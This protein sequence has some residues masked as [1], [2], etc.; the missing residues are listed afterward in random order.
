MKMIITIAIAIMLSLLNSNHCLAQSADDKAKNAAAD[1]KKAQ[2]KV[3]AMEPATPK[4]ST[5]TAKSAQQISNEEN[6]KE[7]DRERIR[8]KKIKEQEEEA[9]RKS[10]IENKP[11]Q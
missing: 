5:G 2:V 9:K 11:K 10:G 6:A 8:A 1:L 7:K 4:E 3:N